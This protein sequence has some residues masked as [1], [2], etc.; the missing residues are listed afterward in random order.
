MVEPLDLP[1]ARTSFLGVLTGGNYCKKCWLTSNRE[2][3]SPHI[4]RI[5]W[6][7]LDSFTC[8]QIKKKRTKQEKKKKCFHC[9]QH[10]VD[11]K[12]LDQSWKQRFWV[13]VRSPLIII[14]YTNHWVVRHNL[15]QLFNDQSRV[16]ARVENTGKQVNT[17][18]WLS[19]GL[20]NAGSHQNRTDCVFIS[21]FSCYKTARREGHLLHTVTNHPVLHRTTN[22]RVVLISIMSDTN[23]SEP[24]AIR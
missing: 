20:N 9:F 19:W 12:V 22:N 10:S 16:V 18:K 23:Q 8:T 2:T 3:T 13:A 14:L 15:H 17:V 4:V 5:G 21:L 6:E 24:S 11:F 7:G 1:C